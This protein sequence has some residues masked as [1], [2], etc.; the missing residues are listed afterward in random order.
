MGHI[1]PGDSTCFSAWAA[2]YQILIE[3]FSHVIKGQFFGHTHNDQIQISRSYTDNTAVGTVFISPSLTT[4]TGLNPSFRI[5]EVDNDT[6][7]IVNYYQY[8]LNLE[9]WNSNTTGPIIWDLA[10]DV[11]SEYNLTDLNANSIDQQLVENIKFNKKIAQSYAFNF[12][13]GGVPLNNLTE[14]ETEEYYCKA[15]HAVFSDAVACV[16]NNDL[17]NDA[18]LFFQSLPGP[19]YNIKPL[20]NLY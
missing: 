16:G 8:R 12:N 10:Y 7:S 20:T 18:I 2:R 3:R 9:K 14:E 15:K 17:Q 1:P 13:A 5:Y 4:F 6:N 11:I 19:W